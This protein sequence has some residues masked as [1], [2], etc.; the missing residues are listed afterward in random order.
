[1]NINR[2]QALLCEAIGCDSENFPVARPCSEQGKLPTAKAF[3]LAERDKPMSEQKRNY[4]AELDLWS[5]ANIIGPLFTTAR[6]YDDQH[7]YDWDKTVEQVKKAIRE[8]TLE[9]YKNGL[10][11]EPAKPRSAYKPRAK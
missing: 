6:D 3:K 10:A 7:T 5:D 4:M 1:V 2:F 11:V 9:S 8:K